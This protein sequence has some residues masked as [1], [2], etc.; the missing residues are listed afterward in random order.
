MKAM[1]GKEGANGLTLKEVAKAAGVSPS[2]VSRV[3]HSAGNNFASLEVRQRVWD[4][5]RE[6]GYVP[7]VQAQ[8]LKK[9]KA[10]SQSIPVIHILFARV[11]I[12]HGDSYFDE[13]A[14][15]VQEEILSHSCQVGSLFTCQEA[16]TALPGSLTI[17][18]KDGLVVLGR[19]H[20][21]LD[22]FI[23]QFSRRVV[24]VTL[25]QMNLQ[26]DHI[27]CDG[28]QA[29]Q[30]AMQ[31]LYDNGHRYIAYVG[32]YPN[33]VRYQAFWKFV[34]ENTLTYSRETMI[35]TPMTAEGGFMAAQKLADCKI[36]P[37]AVFCANDVT[38]IGLLKGLKQRGIVVPRDMSV[39]SIDNIAEAGTFSPGLTTV[40]IPLKELGT[41]A[42]KTLVDRIQKG[43]SIY[44]HVFMP[45]ELLVRESVTA[46]K[47]IRRG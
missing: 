2:T 11:R 35:N 21:L 17:G 46:L 20:K 44:L 39:I 22:P 41:F 31:Y 24:Y 25:N 23:A 47:N 29:T 26:A 33:E 5:V 32:E 1:Q 10:A 19:T 38:A 18:K 14:T 12:S 40:K 15:Y 30:T 13:L 28:F 42:V 4:A 36:R 8:S 37:T 7:N 27:M 43:H 3:I 6:L 9:G 45:S 16:E 34:T